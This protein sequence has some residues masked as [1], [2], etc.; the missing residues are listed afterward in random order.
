MNHEEKIKLFQNVFAPKE[1]ERILILVDT[2][3]HNIKD[4]EKWKDRR[5]MAQEWYNTFKELG[6]ESDFI[7]EI[8]EYQ[9]TGIH[10]T[11]LPNSVI[12][13]I[14]TYNLVIAMTEFSASSSLLLIT[15]SE[16]NQIR[17]ASMPLV[18]KRMETTA[19]TAD[20][21]LVQQYAASLKKILD[22][23]I[24]AKIFF[25]TDDTLFIDLRNREGLSESGDCTK[26]GQCINF[27]SGEACIAPYEAVTKERA[28]FGKSKTEGVW[29]V[30]Y[31]GDLIKYK[32]KNNRI[33]EVIGEGVKADEMRTFFNENESRRNIAELGIGCNPN[34]VVTGNP[35]EDEKVGLHIA[36]GMSVHLGGKV[37]SDTH[38]DIIHAKG[39]PIEGITLTLYYKDGTSIE[40]IRNSQLRYNLLKKKDNY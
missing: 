33:L 30:S 8:Q 3:H 22:E 16:K 26:P 35:L 15:Q 25:S 9:A 10:N 1:G 14:I 28:A 4:N 12:D 17:G 2:P 6:D 23:A 29:P 20:Y 5:K 37:E 24:G 19:F 36:Y 31:N 34:A 21:G 18:E 38:I 40:L 11:P 27:P 7:V 13:K 39:C 32:V